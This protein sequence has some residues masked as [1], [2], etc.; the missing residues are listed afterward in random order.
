MIFCVHFYRQEHRKKNIL[1]KVHFFMIKALQ[2]V[3]F[4]CF[5]LLQKMHYIHKIGL[6]RR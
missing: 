5:V 1:Q 2:K 4:L 6:E 3:H